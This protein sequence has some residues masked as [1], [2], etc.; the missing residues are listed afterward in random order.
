MKDVTRRITLDLSR[1]SNTRVTFA[2][3]A[4]FRSREFIIS[5]LDDGVPYF[6]EKGTTATV[7]VRRPDGTSTAYVATVTDDG[8]VK[9]IAGL[10][11]LRHTGEVKVSVSL[12]DGDNKRLSSSYFVINIEEAVH[13][14][15][16]MVEGDET[17]TAFMDMMSSYASFIE[18]ENQRQLSELERINNESIREGFELDRAEAERERGNAE[19]V[20]D[21]AE[22]GRMEAEAQRVRNEQVRMINEN[23]RLEITDTLNTA[24]SNLLTLQRMYIER[25]ENL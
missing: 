10:W 22:L 24:L 9:Y 25:G 7:N 8:C 18:Q 4:D 21:N 23:A 12:F 2:S 3:Q 11:A 17:H 14:G 6:V 5:L 15:T 1:R 19:T 13:L 16:D 20:R